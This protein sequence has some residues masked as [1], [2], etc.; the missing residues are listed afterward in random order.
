[1]PCHWSGKYQALYERTYRVLYD[2]GLPENLAD[3]LATQRALGAVLARRNELHQGERSASDT[4]D[5]A[6]ARDR[7]QP[8]TREKA[9]AF[10]TD[11]SRVGGKPAMRAR[12]TMA[13][14]RSRR[15]LAKTVKIG[16]FLHG[17][18]V[19]CLHP[20]ATE[21]SSARLT[22][23]AIERHRGLEVSKGSSAV[24]YW[25]A[26][27]PNHDAISGDAVPAVIPKRKK[28]TPT[29]PNGMPSAI[30]LLN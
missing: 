1:M 19:L 12:C 14:R 11:F 13:Q 3:E 30:A 24:F 15:F 18:L 28:I 6:R 8:E 27:A 20:S 16:N 7:A 21:F 25:Q 5:N 17:S 9:S 23:S 29:I 10:S 26:P 22:E 4:R 2:A